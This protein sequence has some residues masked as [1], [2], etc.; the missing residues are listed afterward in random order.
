MSHELEKNKPEPISEGAPAPPSRIRQSIQYF[1]E[2]GL[3]TAVKHIWTL[4][5][6]GAMTVLTTIVAYLLGA[7]WLYPY[8]ICAL[9]FSGGIFTAAFIIFC[10]T[11]LRIRKEKALENVRLEGFISDEKGLLDHDFDLAK[12]QDKFPVVL[13]QIGSYLGQITQTIADS[14]Y[15]FWGKMS[16]D[17]RLKSASKIAANLLKHSKGMESHIKELN[18]VIHTIEESGTYV[19]LAD[20]YNEE[21]FNIRRQELAGILIRTQASIESM[22]SFRENQV[23][24]KGISQDLNSAVNHLI[25]VTTEIIE[26]LERAK[27]TWLKLS[28]T[29]DEIEENQK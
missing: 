17:E 26:I 28:K 3:D 1:T 8:L 2:K 19:L 21:K 14:D 7:V 4:V 13:G 15:E 24:V 20:S 25:H 12:A 5:G 9:V 16:P 18:N 22:S 11:L 23:G 6:G 10:L 27:L 29:L